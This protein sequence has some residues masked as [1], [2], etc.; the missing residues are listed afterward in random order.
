[1]INF[2]SIILLSIIT[3]FVFITSF[4]KHTLALTEAAEPWQLSFQDPATPTMEGIINFHN[5]L[6]FFIVFISIFVS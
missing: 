1:M 3:L 2:L 5:D 4:G 6:M